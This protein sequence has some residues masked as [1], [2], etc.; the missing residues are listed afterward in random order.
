M[1][2]AQ[3][4]VIRARRKIGIHADEEPLQAH[5]LAN[6]IDALTDLL[7]G[8]VRES[9]ISSF[10]GT[11]TATDT[12]TITLLDGSTVWTFEANEPIIAGIAMKLADEYGRPIPVTAPKELA[13]GLNALT[14]QGINGLD[15]K[16]AFDTTLT[17]M[18]SQRPYR[19]ESI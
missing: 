6:G 15:R 13:D 12:V 4:Y 9:L 5:E 18:P 17:H 2:S 19:A 11:N 1:P 8:W 14:A 3:E 10:N 16:S 7:S